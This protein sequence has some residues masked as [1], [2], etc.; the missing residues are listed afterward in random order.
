[1]DEMA[2]NSEPLASGSPANSTDEP[3]DAELVALA[4]AGDEAAFEQLFHR[5]KRRVALIASRFFRSSEQIEEIVQESFM[6]VYFA[7]E[8]F[9]SPQE[10]SFAS[11][12]ARIAFN[13]CYDELRRTR[14]RPENRASDLSEEDRAS[15]RER[16]AG[17]SASGDETETALI[18]RDLAAKL[19]AR[20][21]AEDR[22][23][24]VMLDVEELSVAE[25][26]ELT[27]WSVSK[28]KV[29]A[30]RARAQLRRVLGKLL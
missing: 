12:L 13:A 19:L 2:D 28:V 4:R 1:M 22:L 27:G 21:R 6:K 11:W 24:L 16:M 30:H 15:V 7:L 23:V 9:S 5:H 25:A 10:A 3:A 8:N 26:A 18:E 14:R 17:P 20:L 29:R